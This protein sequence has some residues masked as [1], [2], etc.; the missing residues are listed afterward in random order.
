MV[1]SYRP[2]LCSRVVYRDVKPENFVLGL[3]KDASTFFVVDFGLSKP[4]LDWSGKRHMSVKK[5]NHCTGTARYMSLNAHRGLE[6]SRRD[7][8]ESIG[9][10][11]LYILRQGKLPWSGFRGLALKERYRKI[12]EYKYSIPIE[13]LCH[14]FPVEFSNYLRFVPYCASYNSR[15]IVFCFLTS[16]HR[17]LFLH[18][19]MFGH[20][21]SKK[22][23]ATS[24]CR[25]CLL[26]FSSGKISEMMAFTIGRVR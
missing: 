7:D 6:L 14:G 23:P 17:H 18:S 19:D 10:V 11:L 21:N 16:H 13:T 24:T 4:Y 9:Y 12:Y 22:N 3:G 5:S 8:L 25:R 26:I 2:S 20:L 15:Y 1:S